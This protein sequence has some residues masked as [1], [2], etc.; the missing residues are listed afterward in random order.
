MLIGL[1]A[2]PFTNYSTLRLHPL[3]AAQAANRRA[4]AS[5]Y[6]WSRVVIYPARSKVNFLCWPARACLFFLTL[7]LAPSGF[8]GAATSRDRGFLH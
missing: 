3:Q 6:L 1:F 7:Q 8:V 2:N 5:Y 4:A